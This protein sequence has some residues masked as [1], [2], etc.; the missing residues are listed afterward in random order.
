[1]G[2]GIRRPRIAGY[3]HNG[4]RGADQHGKGVV[5]MNIEASFISS[6]SIFLPRYSGVRRSSILR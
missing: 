5:R 2:S 4:E 1:M 3:G 6:D